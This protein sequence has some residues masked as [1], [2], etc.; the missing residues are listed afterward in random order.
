MSSIQRKTTFLVSAERIRSV[1]S[2]WGG[3]ERRDCVFVEHV[4]PLARKKAASL[5]PWRNLEIDDIQAIVNR[6]Y[7]DDVHEVKGDGPWQGSVTQ[8]LQSWRNNIA[9][10][11]LEVVGNWMKN[12][13]ELIVTQS[14]GG[15]TMKD[16]IADQIDAHL[17]KRP[18]NEGSKLYTL[19]IRLSTGRGMGVS[20]AGTFAN[21]HLTQL[22]Q[23]DDE[24]EDEKPVGALIL[25]MQAVRWSG[26]RTMGTG[27]LSDKKA[28]HF[29]FDNYG[30]TVKSKRTAWQRPRKRYASAA[31][32]FSCAI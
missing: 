8:R 19:Y 6:V 32:L 26:A 5:N 7:G 13:I 14:E 24:Y 21:G 18:I 16:V 25:A 12:E 15:L 10:M 23:F 27:E 4:A 9:T 2:W 31:Q 3:P 30:D 22:G 11:A 17:Q 20:A 29:S 28:K 1:D